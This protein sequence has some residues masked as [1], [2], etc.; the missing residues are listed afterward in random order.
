VATEQ[1]KKSKSGRNKDKTAKYFNSKT[2]E[3]HKL[4]RVRKSSGIAEAENWAT[5]YGLLSWG[6]SQ[7]WW[8]KK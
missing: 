3:K 2:G 5:K 7:D 8:N 6:K 4:K 1:K